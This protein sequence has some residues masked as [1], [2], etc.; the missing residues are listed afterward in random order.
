MFCKIGFHDLRI[1]STHGLHAEEKLTGNNFEIDLWVA[2][3]QNESTEDLLLEDTIDYSKLVELTQT[4]FSRHHDLL[5]NLAMQLIREINV[6]WPTLLGS[7]I[8]IRKCHPM[9]G[10]QVADTFVELRTG[11]FAPC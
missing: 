8:C 9:I 7:Q 11:C 5:E 3:D 6:I 1:S 2:V 4:H 10:A